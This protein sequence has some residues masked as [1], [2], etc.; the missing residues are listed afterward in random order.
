M[1][2]VILSWAVPSLAA[3]IR[4]ERPYP[5]VDRLLQPYLLVSVRSSEYIFLVS[6]AALDI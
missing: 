2:L 4:C 1:C 6:K 3:E 5:S